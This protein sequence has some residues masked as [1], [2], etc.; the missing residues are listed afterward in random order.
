M[1]DEEEIIFFIDIYQYLCENNLEIIYK[2]NRLDL[3][4]IMAELSKKVPVKSKIDLFMTFYYVIN[5]IK[6]D[7]RLLATIS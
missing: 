7:H 5:R 1:N 6:R 2:E 3:I 4:E